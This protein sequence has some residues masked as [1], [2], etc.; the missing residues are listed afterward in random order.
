MLLLVVEPAGEPPSGQADE[1]Q[2]TKG[3]AV[4]AYGGIGISISKLIDRWPSTGP[5]EYLL[6]TSPNKKIQ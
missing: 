1:V 4:I 3:N 6:Y 5:R 2:D